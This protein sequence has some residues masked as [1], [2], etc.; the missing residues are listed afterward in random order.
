MIDSLFLIQYHRVTERRN[1]YISRSD[2]R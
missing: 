1:C 2:E